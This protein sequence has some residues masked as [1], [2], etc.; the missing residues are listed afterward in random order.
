MTIPKLEKRILGLVPSSVKILVRTEITE[1]ALSFLHVRT[2]EYHEKTSI[3]TR[4]DT[5]MVS[6]S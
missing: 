5:G 2:N 1:S 6:F 3:K 4:I